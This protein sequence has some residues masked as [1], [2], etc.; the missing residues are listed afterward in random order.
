ML[1]VDASRRS[2]AWGL[3]PLNAST[4]RF[5]KQFGRAGDFYLQCADGSLRVFMLRMG[6]LCPEWASSFDIYLQCAEGS[7][8]V[9]MLRMGCLCLP[10]WLVYSA[11]MD[12]QRRWRKADRHC[13]SGRII[14]YILHLRLA[15]WLHMPYTHSP[16]PQSPRETLFQ[17]ISHGWAVSFVGFLQYRLME[18]SFR[19]FA[20]SKPSIGQVATFID[21]IR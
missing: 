11:N 21:W 14:P 8:R 5:G 12:V 10:A 18:D 16:R 20:L 9:F 7:L 17:R 1:T 13:T 15:L 3:R 4:A 19:P 6:C 2:H